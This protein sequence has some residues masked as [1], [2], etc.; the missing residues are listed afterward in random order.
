M[1]DIAGG[2]GSPNVIMKSGKVE[3]RCK[4]LKGGEHRFCMGQIGMKGAIHPDQGLG[5]SGFDRLIAR[6]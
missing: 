5:R 4:G 1:S 6:L 3:I 2:I